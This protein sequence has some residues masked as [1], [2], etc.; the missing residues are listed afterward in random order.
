MYTL[1]DNLISPVYR[2][3]TAMQCP[4]S[5]HNCKRGNSETHKLQ[6]V[7]TG[8]LL[9][10]PLA[11]LESPATAA[12]SRNMTLSHAFFAQSRTSQSFIRSP[13]SVIGVY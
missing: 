12:K 7:D 8:G 2:D 13:E 10:S 9:N 1:H 3:I 4:L 5:S 11:E 6:S